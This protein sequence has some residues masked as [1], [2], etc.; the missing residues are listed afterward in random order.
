MAV[1]IPGLPGSPSGITQLS[2]GTSG[3]L[4]GIGVQAATAAATASETL[5]SGSSSTATTKVDPHPAPNDIKQLLAAI[6]TLKTALSEKPDLIKKLEKNEQALNEHYNKVIGLKP[7]TAAELAKFKAD[8]AD[9]KKNL[10]EAKTVNNAIAKERAEA[11]LKEIPEIEKE[12]D[13]A[14]ARLASDQSQQQAQQAQQTASQTPGSNTSSGGGGSSSGGGQGGGQGTQAA[15]QL[16]DKLKELLGG[17]GG[18]GSQQQQQAEQQA[19]QAQAAQQAAE[20]QAQQAQ[21]E[22]AAAEAEA[23]R[24][25]EENDRLKAEQAAQ[26]QTEQEQAE[27]EAAQQ[28]QQ[29]AEEETPSTNTDK[30]AVTDPKITAAVAK[31]VAVE[32]PKLFIAVNELVIAK[33]ATM[34]FENAEAYEAAYNKYFAQFLLQTDPDAYADFVET[35]QGLTATELVNAYITDSLE[36]DNAKLFST[37]DAQVVAELSTVKF[38]NQAGYDAAYN[39]AFINILA[40]TKF[41]TYADLVKEFTGTRP[42]EYTTV[43]TETSTTQKTET[44]IDDHDDHNHATNE[45]AP[46]EESGDFNLVAF[47]SLVMNEV[48]LS[49]TDAAI[50]NAF[51]QSLQQTPA[52]E[53]TAQVQNIVA[54]TVAPADFDTHE[55]K[56]PHSD[57][58]IYDQIHENVV[59]DLPIQTLQMSINHQVHSEFF[60]H[61]QTQVKMLLPELHQKISL[62][63]GESHGNVKGSEYDASFT[64]MVQKYYGHV[65]DQIAQGY[66]GEMPTLNGDAPPVMLH[67]VNDVLNDGSDNLDI[68]TGPTNDAAPIIQQVNEVV[69]QV[70]IETAEHYGLDDIVQHDV[71]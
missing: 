64:S 45:T 14:I 39:Q 3:L 34:K 70:T 11:A 8:L 15:Q 20:Q 59:N 61:V 12:V 30:A 41:S 25:Q 37:I 5:P 10:E 19:Q 35:A 54:E 51:I 50:L 49:T 69:T 65:Y 47:L 23:Q 44:V 71:M 26:Q 53:N 24:L 21:Q 43:E 16:Q 33:L 28:A 32:D 31:A 48:D 60:H 68:L 9:T 52:A 58:V 4:G 46:S 18:G 27:E 13:E 29:Q 55:E 40:D 36:I 42:V 7:Y 17:Q 2:T 6:S 63:V 62:L 1:N 22:K 67:T 66:D 57:N 38:E 56:S